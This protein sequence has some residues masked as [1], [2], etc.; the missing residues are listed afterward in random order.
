MLDQHGQTFA[1]AEPTPEMIEAGFQVLAS[2]GIADDYLEAD[3]SL[4]A[5][6]YRAMFADLSRSSGQ[7]PAAPASSRTHCRDETKSR[8][9]E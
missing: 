5:E 9:C 7:M 2:S 3:K 1:P 8:I 4:V 6:I